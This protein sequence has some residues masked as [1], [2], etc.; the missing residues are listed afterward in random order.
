MSVAVPPRAPLPVVAGL[1]WAETRPVVQ[2]IFAVRY[3]VGVLVVLAGGF[4]L[5]PRLALPLLDCWLLANLA[6]RLEALGATRHRDMGSF[7]QLLDPA[8][9]VFC[10]VGVQTGDEFERHAVTWP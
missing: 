9:L 3:W 6:F 10:V 4:K 8:G 2:A 1:L 7:W 5:P